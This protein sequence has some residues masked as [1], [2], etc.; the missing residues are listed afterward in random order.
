MLGSRL[1]SV[2]SSCVLLLP[3]PSSYEASFF[4]CAIFE[5]SDVM[6]FLSLLLLTFACRRQHHKSRRDTGN[7]QERSNWLWLTN[8][9]HGSRRL[10]SASAA[11]SVRS[12]RSLAVVIQTNQ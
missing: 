5:M 11:A 9:R 10:L 4:T 6:S 2:V 12:I 8:R 3:P 7:E 1:S